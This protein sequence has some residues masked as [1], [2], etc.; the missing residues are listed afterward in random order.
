METLIS[1]HVLRRSLFLKWNDFYHISELMLATLIQRYDKRSFHF[2]S[3]SQ[4]RDELKF[5]RLSDATF[6][7]CIYTIYQFIK[8]FLDKKSL[9]LRNMETLIWYHVRCTCFLKAVKQIFVW[10]HSLSGSYYNLPKYLSTLTSYCTY[11]NQ[12]FKM[13][14]PGTPLCGV[15][16]SFNKI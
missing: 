15:K 13:R 10:I 3:S 6:Y 11:L 9:F 7:D 12:G 1:C 8:S 16:G 2:W 4:T 14:V 5:T